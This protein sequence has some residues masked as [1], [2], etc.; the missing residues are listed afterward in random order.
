MIIRGYYQVIRTIIHRKF[1]RLFFVANAR[2]SGRVCLSAISALPGAIREHL[3]LFT[4]MPHKMFKRDLL[5]RLLKQLILVLMVGTGSVFTVNAATTDNVATPLEDTGTLTAEVKKSVRSDNLA[6]AEAFGKLPLSFEAN[7]GQFD[8]SVR[9]S[10]RTGGY[11]VF[12]TDHETV[13]TLQGEAKTDSDKSE[14]GG[15]VLTKA[16]VQMKFLG[17]STP[18]RIQGQK[19]QDHRTNY[20][21]G[22]DPHHYITDVQNFAQVRIDEIW[23]GIDVIYY[24]NQSNLEFDF[25]ISPAADTSRIGLEFSGAQRLEIDSEGNLVIHTVAGELLQHRPL[26]YQQ[27][28][29]HKQQING[30]YILHGENQVGLEVA[31]Y[32]RSI[33][34][35]IDP[36]MSYS[37][38]LGGKN[39]D[40]GNAIIVDNAGNAYVAGSTY[41]SKFPLQGAYD[42]H[43][44]HSDKDV[45]V[46]K[47]NAAGTALLYSTFIGGGNGLD[48]ATGIALDS[49]GNAYVTGITTDTDFPTSATA[50]QN[51]SSSAGNAFALKLGSMGDSLIYSTYLLNVSSPRIAVDN[52]GN[53]YIAGQASTGFATTPGAFQTSIQTSTGTAPFALKLDPTGSNALYSTVIG[54]SNTDTANGMALDSDGSVYVVGMTNSQDFPLLNAMQS[55]I[56]GT[57]SDGFV[58]KINPAGSG[59][60]YSTLIGG[61]LDDSVNAI[62]LDQFGNAYIAGETYSADFP[63]RNAFQ[64]I[65]SGHLL[66]NASL[67]NA[68]VAK[69]PPEGQSLIYSSFLGGEICKTSCY[70]S[71]FGVPMPRDQYNGDVAYGITVDSQGHAF[72]TGLARTYSFPRSDSLLSA[73]QMDSEDSL[74]VT[75]VSMSGTALV[76]SSLVYTGPDSNDNAGRSIAVDFAGNAY[77]TKSA[78][79]DFPTTTGAFQTVQAGGGTDAAV[80]KLD[81]GPTTLTLESSEASVVAQQQVTLTATVSNAGNGTSVTFMDGR[82]SKGTVSLVNNAATLTTSFSAGVHVLTAIY[83]DGNW[84]ADSPA[85]HLVVDQADCN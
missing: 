24:G 46:S 37:T 50:Y 7:K 51:A 75:K 69:F 15:P 76:Y 59:L 82:G 57:Y 55:T 12:V 35:V 22:N 81:S 17:V 25:I 34:L 78:Q 52:A 3:S 19:Q 11:R 70:L 5:G 67:G 41:S 74:F 2:R 49:Q 31:A 36:V 38:F 80:F 45:F 16:T 83:R 21:I 40:S 30:R 8:K 26:I 79:S 42:S 6:I 29:G 68:F 71:M 84:E 32:D 14:P 13:F 64:P 61:A 66:T 58:T 10:A 28:G 39:R 48:E 60:V 62:S 23:P 72:V 43:L 65:K 77:V 73:K 27:F 1:S 9:F 63:V 85:V 56:K 33:P 4:Q 44:G 54:G 53:A 20:L 18:K 47:I